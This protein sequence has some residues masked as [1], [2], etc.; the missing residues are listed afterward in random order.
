M[1][2]Y[3]ATD[4]QGINC[5]G[6]NTAF[7][8]HPEWHLR[9]D[10]GTVY[11]R[12]GAPIMDP[13]VPAAAAWWASVPL[14]G[15]N[16]TGEYEGTPVSQLIDGVLADSGGYSNVGGATDLGSPGISL[17]RKEAI[18]D[19]K[20]RM[21][22]ALQRALTAANGGIV[23]ANGVSMYGGANADPRYVNDT[24]AHHNLIALTEVGAIMGEHT[25][26]FECINSR[27][28]SF[29]MET[30]AQD[31]D[32][33][34]AAAKFDGGSKAVFVQTW[35]GMYTATGFTPRGE[36]PAHV[37][38]SYPGCQDCEPTPQSMDEWRAALRRHF[39]FAQALFLSIAEPNMYCTSASHCDSGSTS[40]F[41]RAHAKTFWLMHCPSQLQGCMLA[42]GTRATQ[43]TSRAPRHRRP[44][45]RRPS[46]TLISRSRWARR[47]VRGSSC[48]PTCGLGSS[49]TRASSWTSS[50]ETPRR[51]PTIRVGEAAAAMAVSCS[52][53]IWTR[54]RGL[55]RFSAVG[56]EKLPMNYWLRN[57]LSFTLCD[58]PY[59][60]R[61]GPRI[62]HTWDLTA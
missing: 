54:T 46:G 26:A 2:F 62:V 18:A 38:P 31:L 29:N 50:T 52:G 27:N 9:L 11:R 41:S 1:L 14:G 21:M 19:A 33:L 22:G 60:P 45:P 37:Y 24:A 13:T 51:S 25:A 49:S 20:R 4:Q 8:A 55:I 5:Y 3:L 16:G 44:A 59:L 32:A 35:P 7:T 23:M 30:V 10:N 28:N 58:A 40:T 15:I 6:A 48:R 39:G 56:E 12:N 43:A 47:K 17:A 36:T 34:I 57:G 53:G 42:T 61:L